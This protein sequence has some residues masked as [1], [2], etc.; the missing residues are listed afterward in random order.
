MLCSLFTSPLHVDA[1][2]LALLIAGCGGV[3]GSQSEDVVGLSIKEQSPEARA[4]LELCNQADEA[5]LAEAG[6][7]KRQSSALLRHRRGKDAVDATPDDDPFGTLREI[8]AVPDIG[9]ATF[10]KLLALALLPVRGA[11]SVRASCVQA[12]R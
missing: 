1:A 9:P 4:I 11:R 7:A 5:Q 10:K 2:V 8:D 12:E 6:L 3:E